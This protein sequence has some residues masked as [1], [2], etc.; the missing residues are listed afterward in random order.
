M[1]TT[2]GWLPDGPDLQC[3][4]VTL[5]TVCKITKAGPVCTMKLWALVGNRGTQMAN[6]SIYSVYLSVDNKLSPDDM[7]LFTKR[8]SKLK[9]L[10]TKGQRQNITTPA[11][12]TSTGKF[13]IVVV[14]EGNLVFEGNETNNILVN[15]PL[16]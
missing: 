7:K 14:D 15:G 1:T 16:P 12:F 9:P 3:E 11:G 8:V 6:A 4:A 2:I 10:Q 5:D 13:L